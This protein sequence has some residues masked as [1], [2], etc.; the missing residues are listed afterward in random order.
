MLWCFALGLLVL[1]VS[2]LLSV[3]A[4]GSAHGQSGP[5]QRRAGTSGRLGEGA[6]RKKRRWAVMPLGEYE[7]GQYQHRRVRSIARG[8]DDM[9][10]HN[11]VQ[12]ESTWYK[13]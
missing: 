12:N 5:H 11:V 2:L 7:E 8:K 1:S 4:K 10:R 3:G 9:L 13:H 6:A